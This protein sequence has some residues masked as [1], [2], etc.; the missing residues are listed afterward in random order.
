[1]FGWVYYLQGYPNEGSMFLQVLL[2]VLFSAA[3]SSM[4]MLIGSFL[5]NI[6]RPMQILSATSMVIFYASGASF[7]TFNMPEWVVKTMV[8]FPSS[9]MISGFT[10]L[11]SQGAGIYE[12]AP[13]I[14]KISL[15]AIILFLLAMYRLVWQK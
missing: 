11:N 1:M 4:G 2:I 13:V 15:L 6:N 12:L 8:I 7:P 9:T 5:D 14:I 10:M 3:V